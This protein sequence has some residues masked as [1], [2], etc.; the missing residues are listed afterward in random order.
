VPTR[1]ADVF[2]FDLSHSPFPLRRCFSGALSF[3]RHPGPAIAP[4]LPSGPSHRLACGP[5]LGSSLK[6]MKL[7]ISNKQAFPALGASIR[8]KQV[9]CLHYGT[10]PASRADCLPS[11]P[12][13]IPEHPELTITSAWSR[14]SST[15]S[16]DKS[17]ISGISLRIWSTSYL[18]YPVG[19]SS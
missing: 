2:R 18:A 4:R 14:S 10:F 3:G 11:Y 1:L 8:R 17:L 13:P 19:F 12:P 16:T 5:A 6:L 15:A 7:R 9:H